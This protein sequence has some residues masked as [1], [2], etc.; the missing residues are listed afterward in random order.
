MALLMPS[1]VTADVYRTGRAPPAAPDVVGVKV[2]LKPMGASTL[3]STQY[4]HVMYCDPA[5]DVRDNFTATGAWSGSSCDHVY[6]PDKNGTGFSV[7]LVRRLGRGTAGDMLECLLFR[8][9]PT[10][11]TSNL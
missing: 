8:G 5:T 10:W 4:T 1:N 9:N 7:V 2:Y 6:I 11:P 3:T